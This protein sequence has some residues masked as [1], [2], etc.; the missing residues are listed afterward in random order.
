MRKRLN[1]VTCA[2]TAAVA[3]AGLAIGLSFWIGADHAARAANSQP[4]DVP[5][6]AVRH[7]RGGVALSHCGQVC[8]IMYSLRS[9]PSATINAVIPSNDGTGG[10]VGRKMN[11][12]NAAAR[13]PDGDFE[14]SFIARVWQF[15]GPDVHDFFGPQSYLC[16]HDSNYS[17]FEAEWAPNGNSTGL[18]AGVA[19]PNMSGEPITLRPCGATDRTL[20]IANQ[21][22]GSGRN[23]RGAGNYCPWMNGSDSNFRAPYVLTM[24]SSTLAPGNQLRLCQENLLPSEGGMAWKNQEF[25]FFW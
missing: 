24:D 23:C 13:M 22:G 3:A 10:K 19:I 17:V 16:E 20:W 8:F 1:V 5:H 9:G 11:L 2:T 7:T 15:C 12:Q 21:A 18:C 14:M 4:G 6:A 25:A